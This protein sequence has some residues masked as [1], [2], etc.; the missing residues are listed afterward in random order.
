MTLKT[1][2][3]LDL[4]Q[5]LSLPSEASSFLKASENFDRGATLFQELSAVE[6]EDAILQ[7][8]K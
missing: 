8:R 5:L 1:L 4:T 2:S 3:D 7:I 6:L